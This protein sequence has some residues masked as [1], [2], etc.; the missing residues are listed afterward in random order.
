[1]EPKPKSRGFQKAQNF[2]LSSARWM[3]STSASN[4]LKIHFNKF[5]PIYTF[6]ERLLTPTFPHQNSVCTS[7]LP[8]TCHNF[9]S[10]NCYLWLTRTYT[11]THTHTHTETQAHTA[12]GL[13]NRI[14]RNKSLQ[15]QLRCVSAF[16]MTLVARQNFGRVTEVYSGI[17]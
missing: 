5:T 14:H 4:S 11:H 3:Q 2:P 12:V 8:H 1:M 13:A 10:C 7:P 17:S 16:F 6:S 15:L 9:G